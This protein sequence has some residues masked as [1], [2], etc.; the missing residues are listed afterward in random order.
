[1]R[2]KIE[3]MRNTSFTENEELKN[4][5]L[6]AEGILKSRQLMNAKEPIKIVSLANQYG[7]TVGVSDHLGEFQGV[8]AYDR[9]GKTKQL[10]TN[11]TKVIAVSKDLTLQEKR[12]VTAHELGHYVMSDWTNEKPNQS[13]GDTKQ[14][15]RARRAKHGRSDYENTIDYFA[16]CLLMPSQAVLEILSDMKEKDQE[17]QAKELSEIFDVE[18]EVARR[19]I[20]EVESLKVE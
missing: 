15:F 2:D 11:Y 19:R 12:F 14:S 9:D 1:M 6:T 5:R 8:I 13:Y 3:N 18:L 10:G 20:I 4:A 17:S 16:A 7:F